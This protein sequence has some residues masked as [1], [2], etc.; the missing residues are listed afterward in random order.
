MQDGGSDAGLCDPSG[1]SASEFQG[2]IDDTGCNCP[3][4]C[5]ADPLRGSVCEQPCTT[6]PDC[7]IFYESCQRGACALVFCGET[8]L[9]DAGPNGSVDG[10][11]DF[12]GT[13][14]GTCMPQSEGET[15]LCIPGGTARTNCASL[16]TSSL[17]SADLCP[18]GQGCLAED[19]GDRGRCVRLCDP[20]LGSESC[21]AGGVCAAPDATRRPQLGVCLP[22]GAEGCAQGLP[23]VEWQQCGP[24]NACGCPGLCVTDPAN[25][26][27]VVGSL[28][29]FDCATTADCP[30]LGTHCV[31]S[32][33]RVNYC[34]TN[35]FGQP[36]PGHFDG[37]C[38]AAGHGDGLCLPGA[39]FTDGGQAVGVC[40][41][42]GTATSACDPSLT[43]FE[44]LGQDRGPNPFAMTRSALAS[45][46]APGL[47]C[48]ITS[49]GGS[50]LQ[51]CDP[52]APDA[53]CPAG[54]G[55]G[56]DPAAVS[57]GYCFPL[58]GAGCLAGVYPSNELESCATTGGCACPLGCF[59]DNGV[60][61]KLCEVPCQTS[62][63]CGIGEI[64]RGGSCEINFCA[65]DLLGR[66]L[67]GPRFFDGCSADGVNPVSGTC[68][69]IT[70]G[71]GPNAPVVGLCLWNGE[72]TTGES[73]A[74]LVSAGGPSRSSS[75]SCVG[76]DLCVGPG[77]L[78]TCAR[79]CDPSGGGS[80]G[81]I[82]GQMCGPVGDNDPHLGLCGGCSLAGQHCQAP[83]DCC[84]GGCDTLKTGT[85]Q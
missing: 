67:T 60:G 26:E 42:T 17:S 52:L 6:G 5:V 49:D 32:I 73:C 13:A 38:D 40:V 4:A 29:E 76:G 14:D 33:C 18:P 57:V 64:C 51:A 23:N 53:G 41:Q 78:A 2:C 63:V 22:E 71:Q 75:Q 82:E 36:A 50:C 56:P 77:S 59:E 20:T 7:A 12:A 58:G 48:F 80:G 19:G 3:D 10:P 79:T 85:C 66:I 34:G 21:P 74:P 35:L 44:V 27:G 31:D 83:N 37:P 45:V 70:L 28:C 25:G 46:C 72:A 30:D 62:D 55:C 9:G 47:D 84:S 68:Q 61:G 81:C 15:P 69:P 43:H 11:C 16:F 8:L 1:F 39:L 24:G 65:Q 54:Q